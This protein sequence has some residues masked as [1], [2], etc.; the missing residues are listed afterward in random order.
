MSS[1]RVDC[2]RVED[3][4]ALRRGASF[5]LTSTATVAYKT[6]AS[7]FRALSST[8]LVLFR[9]VRRNSDRRRWLDHG[10]HDTLQIL[11]LAKKTT[12]PKG[13]VQLKEWQCPVGEIRDT[14]EYVLCEAGKEKRSCQ[15]RKRGGSG[16]EDGVGVGEDEG[17]QSN[18]KRRIEKEWS[19]T[20]RHSITSAGSPATLKSSAERTVRGR[21]A[22]AHQAQ[23]SL[24]IRSVLE[25]VPAIN[26]HQ[27][28][29]APV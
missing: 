13:R 10:S 7:F 4:F 26:I 9:A 12:Q 24:A 27:T 29:T 5:P 20:R 18:E 14:K 23:C 6:K 8:S 21:Q 2:R 17:Y 16:E 25:R 28:S 15:A 3:E 11:C 19:G 1:G 22:Q